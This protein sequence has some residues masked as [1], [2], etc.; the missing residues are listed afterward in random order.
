MGYIETYGVKF[1]NR[2]V[3]G[4]IQKMGSPLTDSNVGYITEFDDANILL[5]VINNLQFA[6]NGNVSSI[7]DTDITTDIF[8]T[9]ID[10]TGVIFYSDDGQ[11]ILETV[12]LQDI[13]DLAVGWRNFLL[14]PPLNGT[15]PGGS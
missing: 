12:P 4:S 10:S 14:Q 13:Y 11:E 6:I 9:S 3:N 5:S 7:L 8:L 2:V 1:Y 15:A